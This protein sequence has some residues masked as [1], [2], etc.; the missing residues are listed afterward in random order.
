MHRWLPFLAVLALGCADVEETTPSAASEQTPVGHELLRDEA[1]LVLEANCGQ[2][3]I[4]DYDTALP[5][6]LAV[7]DLRDVEWSQHMS[8]GQLIDAAGRVQDRR[9]P[10]GPL[11]ISDADVAR[12]Q[13]YVDA[14]LARRGPM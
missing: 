9:G 12:V 11:E 6:A 14:E 8:G 5:R 2:C 1:R 4:S 7:F 3:H 10:D 13:A